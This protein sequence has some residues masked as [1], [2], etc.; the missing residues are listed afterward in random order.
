MK[1]YFL[2]FKILLTK[3][4]IIAIRVAMSN[5]TFKKIAQ[6]DWHRADIIA[7]LWKKGWSLRRLSL[8]NNFSPSAAK[9][10]LRKPWPKME[11][12]IANAINLPPWEIWPSRYDEQGR[13]NRKRGRP[14][15][16]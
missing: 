10:A 4:K 3:D 5:S 2:L 15:V 9:E 13:P 1:I 6:T 11:G 12:I 14:I 16:K 8:A 7:A